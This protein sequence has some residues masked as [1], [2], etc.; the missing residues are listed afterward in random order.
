MH[1]GYLS[2]VTISNPVQDE[3][4]RIPIIYILWSVL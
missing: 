4:I 2:V 3:Y 1:I